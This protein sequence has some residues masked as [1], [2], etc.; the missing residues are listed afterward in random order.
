MQ[1]DWRLEMS[2]EEACGAYDVAAQRL[3]LSEFKAVPKTGV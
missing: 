3:V 2:V 1:A